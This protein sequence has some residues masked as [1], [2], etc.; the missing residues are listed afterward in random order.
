TAMNIQFGIDFTSFSSSCQV[1]L[2][3]PAQVSFLAFYGFDK[4]YAKRQ[5]G[6]EK[7]YLP[8]TSQ[9]TVH[10]EGKVHLEDRG[11]LVGMG[12]LFPTYGLH[13]SNSDHWTR[14]KCLCQFNNLSEY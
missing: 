3:A 6:D 14:N 10:R 4:D 7:V 2:I 12:S 9:I 5:L 11:Q 13:G 8:Y 1:F